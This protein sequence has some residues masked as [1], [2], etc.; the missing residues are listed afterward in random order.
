MATF[1]DTLAWAEVP[2]PDTIQQ[3]EPRQQEAVSS[4]MQE[5]VARK[6]EGLNEL[7]QAISMIVKYIPHFVVIPLMVE[8]IKPQ[9]A[10]GVC[11]KMGVDQATSYANDLPPEYFTEVS[12]HIDPPMM[13][14]IL[15]KMKK[16]HAEKFIISELRHHLTRMLDI[17]EH[18]E[19]RMLEIVAKHVTLP[20][21]QDDLVKHPHT[22]I[23]NRLRAMQK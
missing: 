10:A 13:A 3:M 8:H 16:H 20:E 19:D 17:T 21:H 23:F 15:G 14:E 11:L 7:Y 4:W 6:T 22:D 9:I 2:V 18:L 12:R 1:S 5:V